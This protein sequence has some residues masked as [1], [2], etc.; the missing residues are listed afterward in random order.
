LPWTGS[1]ICGR[2]PRGTPVRPG[3]AWHRCRVPVDAHR[4]EYARRDIHARCHGR[5]HRVYHRR[6]ACIPEMRGDSRERITGGLPALAVPAE[7]APDPVPDHQLPGFHSHLTALDHPGRRQSTN[8]PGGRAAPGRG[9]RA[10]PGPEGHGRAVQSEA[11]PRPGVLGRRPRWSR[12]RADDAPAERGRGRYRTPSHPGR[13]CGSGPGCRSWAHALLV[14]SGGRSP[15]PQQR[16]P[17]RLP[18][19]ELR[20]SHDSRRSSHRYSR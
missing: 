2:R 20:S 3:S 7:H 17:G 19:C 15:E 5:P 1:P 10:S 4:H 6:A 14:D 8:S 16:L 12:V 13:R 18:S 9:N 11:Q